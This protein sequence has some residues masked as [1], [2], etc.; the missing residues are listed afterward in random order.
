MGQTMGAKILA[1]ASGQ[2]RVL[3]GEILLPKIES[4]TWLD[5]TTFIDDFNPN[6]LRVW[7]PSRVRRHRSGLG[8]L[9][10]GGHE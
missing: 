2:S 9:R 1:R 8:P 3:P 5:G 6:D 7:E 10:H 4:M